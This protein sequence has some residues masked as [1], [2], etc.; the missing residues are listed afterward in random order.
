[1]LT[2]TSL[3]EYGC[4]T[5][6]R[7]FEEVASLYSTNM[8]TVYSGGLVYEYS[9]EVSN[10]GLVTI[11]G[12][13]AD[14]LDDFSKLQQ[15]FQSTPNPSGD[16]GFTTTNKPAQCPP[17]SPTWLPDTDA[18]PALPEGA[19]HFM[20]KGAGPGPGLDGNQGE[21]SQN[22]GGQSTATATP[23]SGSP[24]VT[25]TVGPAPSSAKST[26]SDSAAANT[27]P[28]FAWGPLGCSLLV[29]LWAAVG[30]RLL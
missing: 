16:G 1:M 19:A 29:V 23:G 12:S 13:T 18:L 15:A 26:P 8:T 17:Q 21:G 9:Q 5:N 14:P 7:T 30:A 3:S 25:A 28:D 2:P 6:T 22:A 24:S 11:H 27:L 4:N 10:Y 20:Q